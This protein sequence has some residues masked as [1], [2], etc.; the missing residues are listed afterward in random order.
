[1]DLC[2][3][4]TTNS[5]NTFINRKFLNKKIILNSDNYVLRRNKRKKCGFSIENFIFVLDYR[6][7][8]T[9]TKIGNLF[10]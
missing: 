6:A 2:N 3:V 5:V 10:K 7:K 1:L 8:L 4:T 9:M